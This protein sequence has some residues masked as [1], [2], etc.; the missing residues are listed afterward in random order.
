MDRF[1]P[2]PIQGVVDPQ[3]LPAGL[4]DNR[5][6]NVMVQL[7]ADPVAVRQAQSRAKLSKA[8]KD[9]IKA[10]LKAQQDAIKDDIAARGGQVLSQLQSAYNGMRVRIARN[11]AA[12]LATLPNVVAVRAL[13]VQ[14]IE[15]AVA[16]PYI[17]G[18]QVW[19]DL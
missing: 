11:D 5:S 9:A 19:Q 17:G 3:I 15:N 13:Q 12:S 8:E 14:T 4:D 2:S 6:V 7:D 10:D 16:V 18:P 1:E